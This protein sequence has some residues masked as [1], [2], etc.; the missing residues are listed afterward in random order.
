MRVSKK[1]LKPEV[2]LSIGYKCKS[3]EKATP[4]QKKGFKRF[5]RDHKHG[6]KY[7]DWVKIT[8]FIEMLN[9]TASESIWTMTSSLR[10]SWCKQRNKT[11]QGR[12]LQQL[13]WARNNW[14]HLQQIL[15]LQHS[16]YSLRRYH[17]H[18]KLLNNLQKLLNVLF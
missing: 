10:H 4:R 6:Y 15:S 3:S 11:H 17:I 1:V 18:S 2:N 16:T 5:F 14:K 9:L 12:P 8:T 7:L 13:L